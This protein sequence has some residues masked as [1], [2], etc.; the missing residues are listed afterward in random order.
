MRPGI[1]GDVDQQRLPAGGEQAAELLEGLLQVC[2]VVQGV[3]REDQ[4][5][6]AVALWGRRCAGAIGR[7]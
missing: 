3:G 5:E 2:D 7:R 4:V 6:A 1:A